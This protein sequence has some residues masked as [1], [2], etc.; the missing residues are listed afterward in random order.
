MSAGAGNGANGF[1]FFKIHVDLTQ[2]GLGAFR[3]PNSISHCDG[4]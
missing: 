2:E 3:I 1:E 4:D